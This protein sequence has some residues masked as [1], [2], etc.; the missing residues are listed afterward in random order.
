MLGLG[1][2]AH[3]AHG[4]GGANPPPAETNLVTQFVPFLDA[5]PIPAVAEPVG[6][7]NGWLLYEMPMTV[8]SNHSF[9]TNLPPVEVWGYAGSYPGPTILATNGQP[10][11][12]RWVNQLPAT[13]PPWQPIDLGNHGVTNRD[14]R[15]VVHLHGGATR[16]QYDGHPT[17][18]FKTGESR[19]YLYENIDFTG[20]GETLW[21]H[22]HALGVT[23]NNVYAG[24][25]GFYLLRDHDTEGP[26]NLPQAPYEIPLVFQDRDIQTNG[27]T[28]SL[29]FPTDRSWFHLPV[30]NGV[31]APYLQ[32]E[33]R[34]YRFRMLNGCLFR[35]VG[36]VLQS[37]TSEA[38]NT[39]TMY[40]I[41]TDDG[42]LTNTV[43]IG[44]NAG[45]L[46]NSTPVPQVVPSL[47]LMPGERAD[48]LVDFSSY[49]GQSNLVLVNSFSSDSAA[50]PPGEPINVVGGQ[51][52][53]FQVQGGP[54]PADPSQITNR[55]TTRISAAELA[56]NAVRTRTIT[57]DLAN[58]LRN[59][60]NQPPL[61]LGP[62]FTVDPHVFALLNRSY[63]DDPV[64]E[65]PM[66][67]TVEIWEF[68]NLSPYP[69]PMHIH[70]IDFLL[71]ERRNFLGA[72]GPPG[73][74]PPPVGVM[75]YIADRNA[76]PQSVA[77]NLAKYLDQSRRPTQ[78]NEG[79]PKDVIHAAPWAVTRVV[80]QWPDDPRFVGPYVYHCHIL[81]HEDN[82]MMRPIEV[83]LPPGKLGMV[84]DPIQAAA[85]VKLGT[86]AGVTYRLESSSNLR[87][88]QETETVEG[89]GLPAIV[90]EPLGTGE[91]AR[92]YR[93]LGPER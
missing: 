12:V 13:Y 65:T 50:N 51:F 46:T 30:V 55:L 22:D 40:Q 1:A 35:T 37:I 57:L 27:T 78:A 83:M 81:D 62:P 67:G 73:T 66:G 64:T 26:L 19:L 29:Y 60:T 9:H 20:D 52:M 11:Y 32:V 14:V 24:L 54:P 75:Q 4:S 45:F 63:F 76:N 86:A 88:W 84:L 43:A 92:F 70:L 39:V 85:V 34:K 68:V 77:T 48:V 61:T 74:N 49:A 21:Y 17:N 6:T 56:A 25:A 7:T 72:S 16:P 23:A 38:T 15:N 82:D 90:Q 41:G 42:F 89:T 33:A 8:V 44:D 93:A 5:L 18:T 31:I 91:G 69:H 2:R 3:P 53:Q 71:L 87:T 47:R 59:Q 10:I 58:Q 28:A 79:G 80:M 36:L